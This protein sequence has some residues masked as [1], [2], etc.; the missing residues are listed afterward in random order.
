M[1][2]VS[3]WQVFLDAVIIGAFEGWPGEW[4]YL[5]Q[6][7]PSPSRSRYQEYSGSTPRWYGP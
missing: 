3:A 4:A 2:T 7:V 6:T 1:V 5:S